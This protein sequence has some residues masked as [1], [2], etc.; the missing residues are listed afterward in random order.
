M[1]ALP[2]KSWI[3][4]GARRQLLT[5][6]SPTAAANIDVVQS[7]GDRGLTAGPWRPVQAAIRATTRL[8]GTPGGRCLHTIRRTPRPFQNQYPLFPS[9][10]DEVKRTR[11]GRKSRRATPRLILSPCLAK[12]VNGLPTVPGEHV[13][14][15]P[16]ICLISTASLAPPVSSRT[17][18]TLPTRTSSTDRPRLATYAETKSFSRLFALPAVIISA[19][20]VNLWT[21]RL[22]VAVTSTSMT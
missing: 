20:N 22:T 14:L 2:L 3:F 13:D 12:Q 16:G 11:S 21:V 10:E 6:S 4:E 15:S 1:G 7:T 18:K 19:P 5:R 9:E 17:R 8:R